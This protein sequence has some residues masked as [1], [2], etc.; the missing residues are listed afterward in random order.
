LKKSKKKVVE[1]FEKWTFLKCPI[2]KKGRSLFLEKYEKS[3]LKHFAVKSEK[4]R[5][6]NNA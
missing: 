2:L 6:S 3:Y 4:I 1:V 5:F